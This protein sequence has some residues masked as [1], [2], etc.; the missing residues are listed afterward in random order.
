MDLLSID[1]SILSTFPALGSLPD[2]ELSELRLSPRFS[3]V[4]LGEVKSVRLKVD[5]HVVHTQQ[6]HRSALLRL[7]KKKEKMKN[8]LYLSC[9]LLFFPF[10]FFDFGADTFT[11]GRSSA[12]ASPV[13]FS[14][15]MV[16]RLQSATARNSS[17][18]SSSPPCTEHSITSAARHQTGTLTYFPTSSHCTLS[19]C[20]HKNK[21][22]SSERCCLLKNQEKQK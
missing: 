9:Q 7:K 17:P 8:C 20:E 2:F 5:V 16:A 15:Q 1:G 22:D 19:S 21:D 4:D 18:S 11:K 6:T 10:V 13:T 14:L 12:E 3:T